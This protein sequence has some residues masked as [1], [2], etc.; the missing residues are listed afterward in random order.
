M[1]TKE[2]WNCFQKLRDSMT[3]DDVTVYKNDRRYW[4]V[5]RTV[6]GRFPVY[7]WEVEILTE[8]LD[9]HVSTSFPEY[10]GG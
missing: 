8:M 10:T 3:E 1:T 2:L 7:N 5:Q 6:K 4:I 9:R